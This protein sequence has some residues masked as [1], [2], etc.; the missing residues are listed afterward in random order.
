MAGILFVL[1][2]GCGSPFTFKYEIL[3]CWL[4]TRLE[5][6]LRLTF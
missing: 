4:T 6:L 5:E 1:L 2:F 3:D